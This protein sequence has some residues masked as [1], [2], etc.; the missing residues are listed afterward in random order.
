MQW[1][2]FLRR[3][4]K[5]IEIDE[6]LQSHLR[7]A[8]QDRIDRGESSEQAR[9]A[10]LLELG[11]AGLVKED[12]R[13]VWA[14]VA[15]EEIVQDLKYALR[16][17]RH[18]PGFTAV[19][20]LSLALG[21]GANTA[22]FS[23]VNTL[24]LRT[25]PVRDP[26]Q[27]V[28][29]LSIYPGDPRVN[30]FAWEFY[31]HYRDHNSVFSDLVGVAP[32]R[33]QANVE[34]RAAETVEGGYVVGNFFPALGLEPALGRL[35][36]A[37]DDQPG[38]AVAVVSWPYWNSRFDLDPE[39]LGKQIVVDGATARVIGVTHREFFGLQVGA[40]TDLWLPMSMEPMTRQPGRRPNNELVLQL[41]G[42]LKPGVSIEHAQAEMS[43]LDR[44]RVDAISETSPNQN[45]VLRQLKLELEPAGAGFSQLRDRF[46]K[47]LLIVM[48]V[49]GLLLLLACTNVAGMLLARGA[50]RE[51]ELALRLSL[52]AGRLR[53]VRQVLTES[54]LLSVMGAIASIFVAFFGADALV[55][56]L[57]SE[58]RI[59]GWANPI[60]IQI[61][62]DTVVLLFT[63]G[64]AVL[65]GLLF[66]LAPAVRAMGTAP[67]SPLRAGGKSGET[68]T[69]RWFGRSLVAA[70]VAISLLLLSAAGLFLGH[71]SNLRNVGVG[72]EREDV[73]LVT[74]DTS[75]SGYEPEQLFSLYRELLVR[76]EAI[77]GAQSAT[78]S[79]MTP[80][81]GAAASRF[82]S[83][84][85]FE[86]SP[87]KRRYISL[88]GVAPK[89]FETLGTPLIAGRDFRFRDEGNSRVAII[90]QSLAQY[91]FA[92]RDPLGKHVRLDGDETSYEIVGV[93]GDAKY[94][95]LRKTPPRTLYRPA[96]REGRVFGRNLIVRTTVDPAVV[97]DDVRRVVDDVM[98][99]VPI[100]KVTTMAAQMD[101]TIVPERLMALLSALF[102]GL[103]LLLAAIGLYG[104]LAY[105][106]ARRISEIGVRMALGATPRDATRMVL[107]DA[108]GMVCSGFAI[109]IPMALLSRSFARSVIAGL[110]VD[111]PAP[112]IIGSAVII[113]V[114][115]LA[116]YL[117]A[118]RAAR[119]DPMDAL[120][121]E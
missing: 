95:D 52:G 61:Q 39:I 72:F 6:E 20:V 29:L 33:F 15:L 42:R 120:R 75:D 12:T 96:F 103:G 59:P 19:A 21:I 118:R 117:P 69:G 40:K 91:Y 27:L 106:V 92:A 13:A 77:P 64:A 73:L 68:R 31:E 56:I 37:Q 90:N 55:R 80:L 38:S 50:A 43:V 70:Q 60:E 41:L 100:V 14:W 51:R 116:A 53:L 4:P 113:A 108:L 18:S 17:M 58:R 98:K 79:G 24:I 71:L 44:F 114:S 45:P 121:H 63:A 104:L 5:D 28:E 7:M 62:P 66:G 94:N 23:L 87:D 107:R 47:A 102:G 78:L 48:A 88:N 11:N 36:G 8:I 26:E 99:G 32:S 16:Q 86:E 54:V 109:G 115:L 49:V 83:V 111:N 67:A 3:R 89:Y 65:T 10:V 25:M 9:R 1:T 76:L 93:A 112:M 119:V 22:I 46:G 81:S 84:E 34:G 105:T 57:A 2:R 35:I 85:G 110:P 101:A 97:G 82:V 30:A 74:L